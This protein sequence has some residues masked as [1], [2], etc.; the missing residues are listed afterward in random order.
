MNSIEPPSGPERSYLEAFRQASAMPEAARERVWARLAGGPVGPIGGEAAND[1]GPLLA[2]GGGGRAWLSSRAGL[3]VAASVAVVSGA[4]VLSLGGDEPQHE[5]TEQAIVAAE[6]DEPPSEREP[7]DEPPD[8][9]NPGN[10]VNPSGAV[11]TPL[12]VASSTE[13]APEPILVKRSAKRATTPGRETSSDEPEP[14]VGSSLA[15]ERRLIERTHAALGKGEVDLALTLLRRH[16]SLF[17]AGV[18][19]EER[20]ALLSIAT[21]TAGRIDEGQAAA[22]RFLAAYPQAVL[23]ARVRSTCKLGK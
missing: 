20:E 7:P 14:V 5:V 1:A 2:A 19:V 18:F 10:E 9:D 4:I 3:W 11:S 6:V 15:E 17:E 12:E 16:A 8:P 23:A 21:C 22:Q 13:P